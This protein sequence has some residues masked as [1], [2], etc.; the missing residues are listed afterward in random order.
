MMQQFKKVLTDLSGMREVGKGSLAA[1]KAQYELYFA[2]TDTELVWFTFR[3]YVA[4][5]TGL[6][7]TY[8]R[9][10]VRHVLAGADDPELGGPPNVLLSKLLIFRDVPPSNENSCRSRRESTIEQ[11]S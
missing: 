10:G 11:G 6:H 3:D 8:E 5:R 1:G 4:D 7:V 2:G 9:D